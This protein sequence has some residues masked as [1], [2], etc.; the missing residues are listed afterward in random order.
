[1]IPSSAHQN[2]QALARVHNSGYINIYV[3]KSLAFDPYSW[4]NIFLYFFAGR[5]IS[6]K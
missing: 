3:Q 4:P 5:K 6:C 2:L 1:M